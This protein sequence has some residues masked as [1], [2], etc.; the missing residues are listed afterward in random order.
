[1]T[2]LL[3]FLAVIA[4]IYLLML[5]VQLRA[6]LSLGLPKLRIRSMPPMATPAAWSDLH[7]AAHLTLL[8]LGWRGPYWQDG[9]PL[10][11]LKSNQR[12]SCGA[13]GPY[14]QDG[15][16]LDTQHDV[17]SLFEFT[18]PAA[19][20]VAPD[21]CDVIALRP[22]IEHRRPNQLSILCNGGTP[23]ATRNWQLCRIWRPACSPLPLHSET[24]LSLTGPCKR[25]S[26]D[27]LRS[28]R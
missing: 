1:M 16:P 21:G 9:A 2:D 13:C 4:G 19:C 14:W 23:P 28:V 17:A 15:A 24:P 12:E 18:T 3:L 22:P 11:A 25:F 5:N 27:Y 8:Q 10:D 26:H 6:A 7:E 20:Y